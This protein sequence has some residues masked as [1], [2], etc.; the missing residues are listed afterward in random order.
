VRRPA[1][2]WVLAAAF[3]AP[4]GCFYT[5][6]I[7]ERPRAH[8]TIVTTGPH[9]PGQSVKL[10]ARGS[11]DSEDGSSIECTWSAD[12]CMDPRCEATSPV[13]EQ[14]TRSCGD[15]FVLAL[16]REPDDSAHR[17]IRVGLLVSDRQGAEL[18]ATQT[19]EV[20]NREPDIRVQVRPA[21]TADHAVVGVPVEAAVMASE[22]GEVIDQ[23]GDVVTLTWRL[24]KPRGAGAG[25]ELV[26]VDT[27]VHTFVPDVS[28][29][30]TVEVTGDDG[31]DAAVG[32]ASI[33]VEGDAP[34][35]IDRTTPDAGREARYVL[36]REDGPRTFSVLEIGD[37]LDPAPL[38]PDPAPYLGEPTFAWLLASPDTG[39]DLVPVAGA[40]GDALTIDPSAYAPGDLVDLRVEV[41]DR[42]ERTLPCDSAAPAC[43]IAGDACNQ[44]LGW[45][46]E[47]R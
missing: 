5:T 38:P 46:V 10:S 20:G 7:N 1:S 4:A 3:L 39:G 41:A 8:I 22:E 21:G 28:G 42:V 17:P 16:P 2:A 6:S 35:C 29:L 44:R 47:I 45:G 43:S 30:W 33:S 40:V 23:D 34:P 37:D 24:L 18:L 36:T 9:Y 15:D 31:F 26:A 13:Q 14:T 25:V 32:S 12:A 11:S 19:I 27:E